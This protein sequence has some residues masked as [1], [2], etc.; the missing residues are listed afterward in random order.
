MPDAL[1]RAGRV[2]AVGGLRALP[3]HADGDQE[4]DP[5]PVRDRLPAGVRRR[6][7]PAPSIT[8]SCAAWLDAPPT[9]VLA[10]EV[11][12]LAPAAAPGARPPPSGSR[13][14]RA[15]SR[16]CGA[17]RARSES[18]TRR[19]DVGLRLTAQLAAG[20]RLR[21]RAAGGEPHPLRRRPRPR[22]RARP[23]AALDPPAD[24]GLRRAGSSRRWSARARASTR[25]RCWSP[26]PTTPSWARP[27]CCPNTPRSRPRAGRAVRLHRDRGGAAAARADADRRRARGDRRGRPA[28]PRWWRGPRRRRPTTSSRCTAG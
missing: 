16:S 25:F 11:R 22:R 7:W 9:A 15:R 12:Y 21:G 4:R 24:A 6:R 2:A 5:D 23:L 27:S 19:L 26:P 3:V 8:S 14:R 28:V 18:A 13:S 10:A 17:R 20:R 1:E